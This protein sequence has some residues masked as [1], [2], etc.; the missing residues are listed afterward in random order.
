[1]RGAVRALVCLAT[2]PLA[3]CFSALVGFGGAWH[4]GASAESRIAAGALRGVCLER[5]PKPFDAPARIFVVDLGL[6]Q[7][8]R[9]WPPNEYG[10]EHIWAA[11]C[12]HYER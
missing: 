9:F 6:D 2:L 11:D 5:A 8:V 4:G 3:G 1:M 7:Q 12:R 10:R